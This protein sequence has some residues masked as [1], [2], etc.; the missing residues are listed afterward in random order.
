M[1]SEI[2][3]LYE[4]PL[5]WQV[6]GEMVV[7]KPIPIPE[8]E[9]VQYR[10]RI[11]S[12]TPSSVHYEINTVREDNKIRGYRVELHT[13]Y[14]T[15]DGNVEAR[16][17]LI[18]F[19][20]SALR[21]KGIFQSGFSMGR[22]WSWLDLHSK[23]LIPRGLTREKFI[24]CATDLLSELYGLVED[25]LLEAERDP[26]FNPYGWDETGE[27]AE[28]KAEALVLEEP[29]DIKPENDSD[30]WKGNTHASAISV[31]RLLKM[32]LRI[33][34]YQRPY[35]WERRN[36]I[37]LLRDVED[38]IESSKTAAG[39]RHYRL[40]TIILH[41]EEV[42]GETI[43]N[44]VDGQQ[45]LLTLSLL[46]FCLKAA[47]KELDVPLLDNADTLKHLS[48]Q[49]ES[50]KR[51]HDNYVAIKEYLGNRNDLKQSFFNALY[52]LL[53][54]VVLKVEH[55]DE[56]FQLFD[57]QNTRGRPLDPHDLLKAHH[58]RAMEMNG[59][60][61]K[62]MKRRVMGWE[63]VPP[64]AIRSL[65]DS[66]L[67]RVYNWA[68]GQKTHAFTAKDIAAFKGLSHN[69]QGHMFP[70]V[71]RAVATGH[72]F[73][74]GADF[75]A[76]ESFFAFVE[77]YLDLRDDVND[78][79]DEQNVADKGLA[80]ISRRV[81]SVMH[82]PGGS[83]GFRYLHDL[84]KCVLFCFSDRFGVENLDSRVMAK[85]CRWTYAVM[86]DRDRMS[87]RTVNRY[88]I[89]QSGY[90]NTIAMFTIIQEALQPTEI[91]GKPVGIAETT[92][93]LYRRLLKLEAQV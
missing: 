66:Y 50:Q 75:Q 67:F 31:A 8:Y 53:Q 77:H 5:T 57:S 44:V 42:D 72:E 93:P 13:E 6:D 1:Q 18:S 35:K 61:D 51:L 37:E 16:K 24:R 22:S 10:Q 52:E 9:C 81:Q 17:A 63:S 3:Y 40:G 65:F 23:K 82:C 43:Y 88:A 60:S 84:F 58:L 12:E 71:R 2:E 85:L 54:V 15:A 4:T 90:T 76:G 86:L 20:R 7:F 14:E 26:M 87:E 48:R 39:A 34:D 79:L 70:F 83:G 78:L 33:P 74:I 28:K 30:I 45:R 47:P 80:K 69:R 25:I 11:P 36:V 46:L 38:A 19:L 91:V 92:G 55:E 64:S 68:R 29:T 59:S 73:Q 41:E 89:G 32:N 21:E 27:V 62:Q 56:A 49:P